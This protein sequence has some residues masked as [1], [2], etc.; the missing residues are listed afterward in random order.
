MSD[1]PVLRRPKL[2]LLRLAFVTCLS[3]LAAL[4]LPAFADEAAGLGKAKGKPNAP[5]TIIEYMSPTC[6][7]CKHFHD[8]LQPM[9]QSDYIAT[10][11]VRLEVREFLRNEA[12]LAIASLARCSGKD[13]TWFAVMND[14]FA[15]QT[16]IV[17]AAQSGGLK[18][19]L[20]SLGKA[21][22]IKDEAA[23]NACLENT[24]TRLD[25]VAISKSVET[26][27]IMSTPTLIVNGK[28]K[29]LDADLQSA[30]AFKTYLDRVV[31]DQS[32]RR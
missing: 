31:A 17:A 9:L 19:K 26:L 5:I 1:L 21:H 14:A 24:N 7:S 32:V 6:G 11:K 2:A 22:G 13:E 10:G 25:L 8:K 30:E 20:M 16:E 27:D 18:D 15:Q 29:T 4:F 23:F 28:P 12:D 3:A